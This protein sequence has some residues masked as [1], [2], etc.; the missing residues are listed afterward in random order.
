MDTPVLDLLN[1]LVAFDTH[2]GEAAQAAFL[3]DLT[4]A[5]GAET[6]LDEVAPGRVNVRARFAGTGPGPTLVLEAHGDTVAG[7]PACRHDAAARRYYGRGACDTKGS[8]TA[9]LLGIRAALDRGP[10]PRD[11][12]FAST[13]CEETGGEGARALATVLPPDAHVVVGEPTGLRIVRA[14]KGC[15]R[16]RI[17]CRGRAAH[18]SAP[19][20]GVNAI[21]AMRQ[22]LAALEE[23]VAPAFLER[24]DPFL[25]APT[26]SVGTIRGGRAANVVPD[27]C[28]IEV[29]W[30]LIPGQTGAAVCELLAR[31][32]PNAEIEPYE[33]YPPFAI[34]E[35]HPLIH[36]LRRACREAGCGEPAC[37]G[38]PWA[39]NAGL[40]QAAAGTTCVIFGPGDIAQAHTA[41]E[42]IALAE[43]ERA[44][45]VFTALATADN[46]RPGKRSA[47]RTG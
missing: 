7:A 45:S 6:F 1:R 20:R 22:V 31:W 41:D 47:S 33:Y 32:F 42:W 10:L 23:E 19:E 46:P 16:T 25:G 9:M 4:R 36:A 37:V 14:H 21:Y 39:A 28:A 12:V 3:A 24:S 34:A 38:A 43:V 29:D 18:S 35:T 17:T 40:M 2:A 26:M 8:M 30:R 44:V 27:S 5:W 13:C 11:V 15:Y